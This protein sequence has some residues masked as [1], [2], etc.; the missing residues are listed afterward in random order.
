[1]ALRLRL[2]GL[3][4]M[5]MLI[6]VM[7]VTTTCFV[8]VYHVHRTDVIQ[9]ANIQLLTAGHMAR[10][11]LGGGYH[12]RIVDKS[13]IS[14]EE[15]DRVVANYDELCLKLGLQYIWSLMELDGKLVFTTATH[16]VLTNKNSDCATFLEEH[17]NPEAYRHAFATMQMEFSTFHDK[18]GAGRMVLLPAWDPKHRKYLFAAST[19]MD[20]FE[21]L[22]RQT[23]AE[24]ALVGLF[25]FV[26]FS[27]LAWLLSRWLT[28]PLATVTNA[29]RHLAQGQSD[30]AIQQYGFQELSELS[31]AFQ[32]M[33]A[34]IRKQMT[35]ACESE[36]RYRS[37]VE[38]LNIGVAWRSWTMIFGLFPSTA[39][40]Q[41][42]SDSTR[43]RC[44][45]RPCVSLISAMRTGS[46]CWR[47]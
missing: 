38:N 4:L 16:S 3:F 46:G 31:D 32:H 7:L 12:S 13:S 28:R 2:R 40:R 34:T 44:A 33:R 10:T 15:F 22:M 26:V 45:T 36:E 29:I 14:K 23:L 17:T 6:L 39:S 41:K 8:I 5:A 1:M 47:N 20:D 37:L 9:N 19:R 30:T 11:L 35:T 21:A 43:I 42:I 24:S 25:F 18:W 27:L